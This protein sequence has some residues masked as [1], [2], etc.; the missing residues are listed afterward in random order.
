MD[1]HLAGRVVAVTGAASGIGRATALELG[2]EGARVACLDVQDDAVRG[3]AAE[4]ERAGGEAFALRLDVMDPDS[5]AGAI[6]GTVRRFGALH[7]LVNAAGVGGFV[8]FEDMTLAEW[9]RVIGVNLTG[10][11]LMCHAALP[12]L[13]ATE[14]GSIVNLSSIAG[15]KGQAYSCAYGASK[16]G[17][18]LLTR[19][20][21]N[22]FAKRKLRVN[23]VC[24]GGVAT[25]MLAGFAVSGLDDTLIE[26]MQNPAHTLAQPE[27]V[28]HLIAFLVSDRASYITGVTYQIDGGAIA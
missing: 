5:V 6:D 27:E 16:G 8:R 7:A 15:L 19:G 11:F 17:V 20:L 22:E 1:L 4:I 3:T 9:S 12:H 28:A 21:A 2:R 23:A 14:G 25:P 13:L 26:R 24:P 10:T 18:A